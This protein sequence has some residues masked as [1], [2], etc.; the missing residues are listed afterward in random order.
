MQ[1]ADRIAE[2]SDASVWEALA[3]YAA[4]RQWNEIA[5]DLAE[6]AGRVSAHPERLW[7]WAA[8]FAH[9]AGDTARAQELAGRAEAAGDTSV[10]RRAVTAFFDSERFIDAAALDFSVRGPRYMVQRL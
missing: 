10:L 6:R 4:L 7:V 8:W 2:C 5:S 1:L 3:H 9:H